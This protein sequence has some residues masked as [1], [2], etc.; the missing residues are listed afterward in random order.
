MTT[1]ATTVQY[2]AKYETSLTDAQLSEWLEDA[3]SMMRAE[4]DASAVAYGNPSEAFAATLARVCRDAAHRAIGDDGEDDLSIPY[5]ATQV[6]MSGGSY[7]R[8]F[9]F[10]SGG[11]SDLFLTGSEKLALG[12][13][14]PKACVLSPYGGD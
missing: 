8:G 5:G 7:S 10:G 14:A 9:S 6:N 1:F 11:Y 13:G 3:S 12:I 2:R 4:M